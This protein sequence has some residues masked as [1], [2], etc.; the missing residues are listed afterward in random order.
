MA[1]GSGESAGRRGSRAELAHLL[2]RGHNL[3]SRI[4]LITIRPAPAGG[5]IAPGRGFCCACRTGESAGQERAPIQD[6]AL[7]QY[8]YMAFD[9]RQLAWN[10]TTYG[11]REAES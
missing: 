8:G 2:S 1:A 4:E 10:V 7:G 9:A 11:T 6:A 3:A 5:H